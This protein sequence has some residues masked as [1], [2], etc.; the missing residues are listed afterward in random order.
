MKK[1]VPQEKTHQ[2]YI[3]SRWL[4]VISDRD[5]FRFS[6]D[7]SSPFTVNTVYEGLKATSSTEKKTP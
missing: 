7:L 5:G 6:N 3:M 1:N 4:R 2:S